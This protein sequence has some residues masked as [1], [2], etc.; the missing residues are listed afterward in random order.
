[1]AAVVKASGI[2]LLIR[3][4]LQKPRRSALR[5]GSFQTNGGMLSRPGDFE[6]LRDLRTVSSSRREKGSQLIE[7]VS[8]TGLLKKGMERSGVGDS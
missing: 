6:D 7:R 4:S 5:E 1:M 2:A 3:A 8:E